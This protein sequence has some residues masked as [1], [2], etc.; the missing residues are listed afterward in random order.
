MRR[1]V[2]VLCAP[3]F[4]SQLITMD[5]VRTLRFPARILTIWALRISSFRIRISSFRVSTLRASFRGLI[6]SSIA[7]LN[8][9]VC[10]KCTVTVILIAVVCKTTHSAMTPKS[11]K[12]LAVLNRRETT[13]CGHCSGQCPPRLQVWQRTFWLCQEQQWNQR[14]NQHPLYPAEA[15]PTGSSRQE[16]QSSLF[17]SIFCPL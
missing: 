6:P 5:S 13:L 9:I 1:W 14:D 3:L 12:Y 11:A 7:V 17:L 10:V 4:C 15:G 2:P 8:A 16:S